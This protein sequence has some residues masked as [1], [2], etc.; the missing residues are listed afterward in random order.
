MTEERVRPIRT[1][2]D[3]GQAKH[4]AMGCPRC[5]GTQTGELK[6]LQP[7]REH[8]ILRCRGCGHLWAPREMVEG[9]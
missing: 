9:R 5:G 6:R 2:A 8:R 1:Q 4:A 3:R 7:E